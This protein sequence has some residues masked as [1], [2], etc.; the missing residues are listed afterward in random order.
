LDDGKRFGG[1]VLG[2]FG[3]WVVFG[4]NVKTPKSQNVKTLDGVV[5]RVHSGGFLCHASG[6][7]AGRA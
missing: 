1:R 5:A 6:S 2:W 7:G 4:G 3:F